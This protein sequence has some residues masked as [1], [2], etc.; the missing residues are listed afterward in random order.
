[1]ERLEPVEE[2]SETSAPASPSQSYET[3]ESKIL[4]TMDFRDPKSWSSGRKTLLFMALM[5]SSLLA[6][7][8]V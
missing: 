8:Y 6:D 7:G 5:S 3:H 4:E 2:L 1:M